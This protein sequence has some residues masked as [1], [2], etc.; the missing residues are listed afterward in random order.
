MDEVKDLGGEYRNGKQRTEKWRRENFDIGK[1]ELK[2]VERNNK[3]YYRILVM[4]IICYVLL[5]EN[6][7]MMIYM[8]RFLLLFFVL[9][10]NNKSN[11]NRLEL[12][13]FFRNLSR[14]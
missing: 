6:K 4:Q 9:T 2:R 14:R 8:I 1:E 5:M 7:T 11:R 3:N 12:I 10:N 13:S